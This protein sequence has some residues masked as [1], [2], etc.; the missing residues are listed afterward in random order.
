[1][2]LP[3]NNHYVFWLHGTALTNHQKLRAAFGKG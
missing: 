3:V 1:M 2:M